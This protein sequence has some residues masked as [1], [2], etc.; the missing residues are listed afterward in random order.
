MRT[1]GPQELLDR[2]IQDN[3]ELIVHTKMYI[4]P[5]GEEALSLIPRPNHWSIHQCYQHLHLV[6]YHYLSHIELSLSSSPLNYDASGAP[7]QA[8][9]E[10]NRFIDSMVPREGSIRNPFKTLLAF[11]PRHV[12]TGEQRG[13]QEV[14]LEFIQ[15][16]EHFLQLLDKARCLDLNLCKPPS[17]LVKGMQFNLGDTFRFLTAHSQRH[18]WQ[19]QNLLREVRP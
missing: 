8:D 12:S 6:N 7:F 15:L 3:Q 1:C 10:A 9:I 17:K 16:Q 19:I 4:Q 2:L 14:I 18:F 5:L 13:G 11:D